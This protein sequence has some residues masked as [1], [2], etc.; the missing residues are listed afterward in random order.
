MLSGAFYCV[1]RG[2]LANVEADFGFRLIGRFVIGRLE[3]KL[4][5]IPQRGQILIVE[6][7][8]AIDLCQPAED[9]GIRCQLL[10]HAHES[11][12]DKD[13]HLHSLRGAQ[14][15]GHHDRAVFGESVGEAFGEFEGGEVVA[16]CDQ[17]PLL[18]GCELEHEVPREAAFVAFDLLV[19]ALGGDGV[20]RGQVGI[21]DDLAAADRAD[22]RVNGCGSAFRHG[23][24]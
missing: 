24:N 17:L 21:E 7:K 4:E 2:L 9:G 3:Q 19:E 18:R 11:A 20:D 8:R 15:G 5:A 22:D 12:H 14:D 23:D 16:F 13:A 10:A 1:A 6:E